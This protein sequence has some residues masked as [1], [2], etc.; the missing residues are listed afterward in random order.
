MNTLGRGG[1]DQHRHT[2]KSQRL[3][4]FS[5][6]VR[7]P[8]WSDMMDQTKCP[9]KCWFRSRMCPH[10]DGRTNRHRRDSG[11]CGEW[12]VLHADG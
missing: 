9:Q 5:T 6:F 7:T 4:V 11:L 3:L 10:T 8:I 2:I 12:A 1:V